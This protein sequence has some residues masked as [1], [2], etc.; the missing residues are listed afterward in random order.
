MTTAQIAEWYRRRNRELENRPRRRLLERELRALER[1]EPWTLEG[2][3]QRARLRHE[4][5]RLSF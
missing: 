1:E 2:T 3:M 4:I 5:E